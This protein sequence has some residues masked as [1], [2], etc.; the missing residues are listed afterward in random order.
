MSQAFVRR[1]FWVFL[2]N[3]FHPPRKNPFYY[4]CSEDFL[5]FSAPQIISPLLQKNDSFAGLWNQGT[6]DGGSWA[7]RRK[8]GQGKR[9]R[10]EKRGKIGKMRDIGKT[11]AL[12]KLRGKNPHCACMGWWVIMKRTQDRP[13]LPFRWSI[14]PNLNI[15][16]RA[17]IRRLPLIFVLAFKVADVIS[18]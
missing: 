15:H 1:L 10:E 7:G 8:R 9:V 18:F 16:L 4:A 3:S 17:L 13:T 5:L 2:K 12:R 11:G 6:G 14:N